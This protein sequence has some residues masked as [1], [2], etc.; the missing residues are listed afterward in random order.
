M[1]RAEKH[2]SRYR[3]LG[4]EKAAITYYLSTILGDL[5]EV[6]ALL[7]HNKGLVVA[8]KPVNIMLGTLKDALRVSNN[9]LHDDPAQVV[10]DERYRAPGRL[11]RA[12]Y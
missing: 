9:L 12:A 11:S 5:V 2:L 1:R 6:W 4:E 7:S 3:L 8:P 10:G